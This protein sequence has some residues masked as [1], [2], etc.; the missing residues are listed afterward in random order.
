MVAVDGS[1]I[2]NGGLAN[3]NQKQ[4]ERERDRRERQ[5]EEVL[6]VEEKR[7]IVSRV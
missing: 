7:E 1:S 3:M 2:W 4:K 6:T 5:D